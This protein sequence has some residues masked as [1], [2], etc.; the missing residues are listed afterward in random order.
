MSKICIVTDAWH[1]QI[2]G[3][4]TT[5]S[6]IKIEC[7]KRGHDVHIFSPNECPVK[8]PLP[9]YSEINLGFIR[10]KR[11]KEYLKEHKFDH[12]HIST[13]EGPIGTIFRKVLNKLDLNYTTAYHTKFPEFVNA[14]YPFVPISLG[15]R[16]MKSINRKSSGILVPT[17]SVFE[18]LEIKGYDKVKLWTRGVDRS[19]F[20]PIERQENKTPIALCV[21]RVSVEKN[22]E[23]FFKLDIPYKKIMV[24]GGPELEQYKKKYKDVEFTGPKRG[25]E[26]ASYYQNADVFVFP[27][28]TD[29]FG[30][31]MIEALAC[32][33]PVAAYDVT[34]PKDVVINGTNG[35]IGDN[36]KDNVLKCVNV[37]I[38]TILE[39]SQK[40]QWSVATDQFL[41]TL[42]KA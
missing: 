18:E 11:V 30:V 29:T 33:L 1:P 40:Y 39:S 10:P 8:M 27:S 2:N 42:V 25:R 23:K 21:S 36:L 20:F 37:K 5:L 26:L 28:L 15:A 9:S 35:Y 4:V 14:K 22:L 24:G 34:G 6:N 41:E 16:Y 19:L 38:E 13:P 17:P 3:V 12:I 7:E 32:G 31:V